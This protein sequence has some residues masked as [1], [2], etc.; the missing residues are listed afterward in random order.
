[1]RAYTFIIQWLIKS[2]SKFKL[3]DTVIRVCLVAEVLKIPHGIMIFHGA[4]GNFLFYLI[5]PKVQLITVNLRQDPSNKETSLHFEMAWY[6]FF[7]PLSSNGCPAV[8][9]LHFECQSTSHTFIR[10][11][12]L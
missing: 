5:F 4:A 10:S 12:T 8:W 9:Y 2:S 7:P 6:D 11:V 1:M 3:I